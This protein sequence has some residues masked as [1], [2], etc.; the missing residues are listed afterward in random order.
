MT[1]LDDAQSRPSLLIFE[2]SPVQRVFWRNFLRLQSD[3]ILKE[4]DYI[5]TGEFLSYHHFRFYPYKLI[6]LSDPSLDV[7]NMI[8]LNDKQS[9][10]AAVFSSADKSYKDCHLIV[11]RYLVEHPTENKNPMLNEWLQHY[12]TK[13]D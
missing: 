10:I 11:D 12:L 8:K 1:K 7:I 4:S 6:I 3:P 2:P 9:P 5:V 13:Q